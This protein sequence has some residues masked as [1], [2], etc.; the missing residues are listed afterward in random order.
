MGAQ[1]DRR[2]GRGELEQQVGLDD[3]EERKCLLA[4][5]AAV[6]KKDIAAETTRVH[7]VWLRELT[8]VPRP[9]RLCRCCIQQLADL[10]APLPALDS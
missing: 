10:L 8:A 6:L 5:Q 1:T 7:L 9:W 3:V 4:S 2:G